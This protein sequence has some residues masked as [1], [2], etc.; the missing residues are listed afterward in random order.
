MRLVEKRH[1][2]VHGLKDSFSLFVGHRHVFASL[3]K[4]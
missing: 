1:A 3:L 2:F 4:L